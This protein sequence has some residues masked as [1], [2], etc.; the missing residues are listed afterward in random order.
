MVV[1][2]VGRCHAH[3]CSRQLGQCLHVELANVP[4]YVSQPAHALVS[5]CLGQLVCHEAADVVLGQ[6]VDAEYSCV[7]VTKEMIPQ[8]GPCQAAKLDCCLRS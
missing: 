3:V 4:A 2:H 6:Y 5:V 8:C 7:L 1:V